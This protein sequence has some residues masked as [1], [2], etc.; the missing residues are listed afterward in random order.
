MRDQ[1]CKQIAN[2][3]TRLKLEN[4]NSHKMFW[5]LRR[6]NR[7]EG[8]RGNTGTEAKKLGPDVT[9]SRGAPGLK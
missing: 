5:K 3:N 1:T 6:R 7:D 8:H 4:L 9:G 2:Q